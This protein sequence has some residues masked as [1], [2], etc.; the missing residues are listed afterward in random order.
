MGLKYSD[1]NDWKPSYISIVDSPSHPLAL[2]EV[3]NDDDEFI[4]KYVEDKMSEET[5]NNVSVSESFLEKL[6]KGFVTKSEEP[7]AKPPIKNTNETGE[8]DDI[9]SILSKMNEK[10]DNIDKRVS[11][12][13]NEEEKPT[14]EENE[15]A[16]GAVNKSE[17]TETETETEVET[18]ETEEVINNEEVITKSIDPD[19]VKSEPPKTSFLA[20]LGRDENGMKIK[21]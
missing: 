19:L 17:S 16:P 14:E 10:L 6:M 18:Q 7:P 4:K 21:K 8:D 13:E 5:T 1:V 15:A 3:Y 12:L 9:K 2:F 11:K 20:R